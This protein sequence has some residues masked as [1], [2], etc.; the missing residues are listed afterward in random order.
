MAQRMKAQELDGRILR[1][2]ASQR[3]KLVTELLQ[4]GE[5][6]AADPAVC[7][8]GR[9]APAP[10]APVEALVY[11]T[12]RRLPFRAMDAETRGTWPYRDITSHAVD[13]CT[14]RAFFRPFPV[15]TRLRARRSYFATFTFV[16]TQGEKFAA[17]GSR[18]FLEVIANVVSDTDVAT[19]PT[20]ATTRPV[21]V[22]HAAT[23]RCREC[24]SDIDDVV[25]YC[26]G[27]A[28]TIVSG[29]L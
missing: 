24:G 25:D 9:S 13:R 12:D 6:L 19:L 11:A 3:S 28:R 4:P 2:A 21:Y 15:A 16:T 29:G 14:Y 22:E 17:H 26:P 20:M 1:A 5:F 7:L 27:C 10:S 18:P 23:L 8:F